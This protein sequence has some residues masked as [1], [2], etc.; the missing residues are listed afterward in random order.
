[1]IGWH[2]IFGNT[3]LQK[4]STNKRQSRHR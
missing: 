4:I 1:L 3:T 2:I